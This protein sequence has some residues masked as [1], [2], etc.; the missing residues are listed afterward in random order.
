MRVTTSA[1]S[2]SGIGALAL[3]PPP[4]AA[5][6]APR[7]RRPP[8]RRR[9][10]TLRRRA[11]D[12]AHV[13]VAFVT[14]FPV[15]FFT[16]MDDAAK[17][18]ATA[19]DGRRRSSYFSC[20]SPSDVDC[21][22]A[23]IED[24]VAKGFDAIVITPMGTE[25]IPALD[26][27][28]DSG[29]KV[30]LVDNDLADFT[31]KT[32]VAAT[33]N[34]NGG[35]L[36]GEYLE[37]GAQGG[38]HDRPDGGRPRRAG[39]R[40]PH[41]GRQGRAG[42]HRRQGHHRRRRDQVRLGP[43]RHGRR[44]P[45]HPRAEPD[46]DLLG[47]RRPGDRRAP[48]SPSDQGKT[49]LVMGYDG[50]PDAA[51]A[52]IDGDMTATIAQFPGQMAALGVEA[53]VNAVRGEP[54]EPFIDTGT[55]LVTTDNAARLP[56]V[57]VSPGRGRSAVTASP[58]PTTLT[59]GHAMQEALLER[60]GAGPRRARR[61]AASGPR[62]GPGRRAPGRHLRHR[63]PR[64]RRARRTSSRTPA[65]SAT[66][67]RSRCSRSA[68]TS[69]GVRVGDLCAVLP[70]LSLRD[71]PRLPAGPDQLLR[72]DRRPRASPIDGG[73]RE[74][75][76]VPGGAPVPR[77]GADARPAGAR[78]DARHRVARRCAGPA[79]RRRTACSSWAPD[80]SAWPSPRR[81]RLR[82]EHVVIADVAPERVAFAAASGLRAVLVDDDA[83][84][85]PSLTA[86]RRPPAVDGV[87]RHRATGRRWR[88]RSGCADH[89]GTR[90]L[91]RPHHGRHRRSTTR[92]STP[93]SST[94]WPRATRPPP[95]G[96]R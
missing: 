37:V 33:D 23:Q 11:A 45:A 72:A 15:E 5:A 24:A 54:V 67:S 95:T 31:K 19:N 47:L 14:K 80:R 30:V 59:E 7:P 90:G 58:T 65:C 6:P 70:Y 34:V 22:I 78:R 4:A 79:R 53:A 21:Q 68:P 20:K 87:R 75:M 96:T 12:A 8:R 57:P 46:R 92:P 73:L 39:A 28:A 60:P 29:V 2:P 55:E 56:R 25:V 74:R 32:A 17:A 91:R 63:P 81:R 84:T 69:T 86:R 51:K 38:R 26:A 52:I 50:L 83:S 9:R 43:G 35:Q 88:P 48:R 94:S 93:A 66:S 13:K 16:A 18:Y 77:P 85:R 64:V 42:G 49:V 89:G 40:R 62:R 27:A 10:P 44:G 1:S 36:A 61:A 82:T 41:P 71:V 3:A 76:V